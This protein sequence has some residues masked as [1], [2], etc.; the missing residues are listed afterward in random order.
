M[1][2]S[3]INKNKMTATAATNPV[4]NPVMLNLAAGGFV[5]E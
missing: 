3:M 5:D 2:A 1:P 4:T